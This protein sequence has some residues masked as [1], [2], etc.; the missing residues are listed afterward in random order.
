MWDF[1]NRSRHMLRTLPGN[2]TPETPNPPART[3][4][5][6]KAA[7]EV[8]FDVM[9]RCVYTKTLMDDRGP[10]LTVITGGD[11]SSPFD[12]GEECRSKAAAVVDSFGDD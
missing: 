3:A 10:K 6:K 11:P 2:P 1:I 12:F 9:G 5:E 8:W 7:D 4:A